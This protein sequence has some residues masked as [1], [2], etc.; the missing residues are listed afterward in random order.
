MQHKALLVFALLGVCLAAAYAD[1]E[2]PVQVELTRHKADPN[3]SC[4]TPLKQH[5]IP[6][7]ML[8]CL[9]AADQLTMHS[10]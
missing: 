5:M 8:A 3:V 4:A 1:M 2:E 10:T 7:S 6:Y 9:L